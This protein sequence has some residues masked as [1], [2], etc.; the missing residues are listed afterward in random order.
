MKN[1]TI[2]GPPNAKGERT[3]YTYASAKQMAE[4]MGLLT[5]DGTINS[6]EFKKR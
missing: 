4:G 5:A 6:R 3:K 2:I 1:I